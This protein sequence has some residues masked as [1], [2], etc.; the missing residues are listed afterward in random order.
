MFLFLLYVQSGLCAGPAGAAK[1]AAVVRHPEGARHL[2]R[3]HLSLVVASPRPPDP[4]QGHGN[5]EVHIVK[6]MRPPELKRKHTGKVPA[7]RGVAVILQVAGDVG[8]ACV[9]IVE[10]QGTGPLIRLEALQR[11]SESLV[12][13]LRHGVMVHQLKMRQRQ[14]RHAFEAEESLAVA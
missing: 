2:A 14:V 5:H 4:V 6:V 1:Q 3:D 13:A 7:L 10:K 8:K 11:G 9:G 12:V